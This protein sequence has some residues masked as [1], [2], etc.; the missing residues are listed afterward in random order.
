MHNKTRS[1][2]AGALMAAVA[3][4]SFG[5]GVQGGGGQAQP[6]TVGIVEFGRVFDAYPKVAEGKKRLQ[7]YE[8]RLRAELE[9]EQAKVEDIRLVRSRYAAGTR[10]RDLKDLELSV[11]VRKLEL[12]QQ[13]QQADL[14]REGS[15][16]VVEWYEDM[17]R[18]IAE[19]ARN[20]GVKLVVR[21]HREATDKDSLDAKYT[22]FEKRVVWYAAD[23][24][25]LTDAVIKLLQVP[26]AAPGNGGK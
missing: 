25:D 20:K 8:N 4:G 10:E 24:I 21:G 3:A 19:V 9:A 7:D 1:L 16:F 15:R 17:E 11:A 26:V 12:L 23:A 5:L 6:E 13:V 2:A 18:A 22:L 14:N